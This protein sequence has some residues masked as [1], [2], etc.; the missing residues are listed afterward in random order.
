MMP[1]PCGFPRELSAEMAALSARVL[2]EDGAQPDATLMP[3]AE[4]RA[5]VE[6][7]NARWNRDLP[8]LALR[9]TVVVDADPVLGSARRKLELI[10]PENARPGALIFVHGGGFC[11][12]S[13]AT[14]ERCARLMAVESGLPV[15]VPDYRLA[16]EDSFPA[17]LHD[18]IAA[19]RNAFKATR[20][21]GVKAGPLLVAGDSAGANLA[22]AALLH[23]QAAG[24][25][26]IAGALLFYGTY[27]C[28]F[29]TP[30]Y[31]AFADGP[32]LTQAKMQRYWSAYAG[33]RHVERLAA[34]VLASPLKASD[35]AL[36]RLP[37]LYLM[38]AGIDPLL[39]DTLRLEA[40]LGALGR[41]ETT[42]IH[43]GVVHGFLQHSIDL[44]AAREALRLAGGQARRM[45][46]KA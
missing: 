14:H 42:T 9:E 8:P 40:R 7:A 5:L 31:A 32:G 10:V 12:C 37:P 43:P 41:S 25:P 34:D 18:V 23:E 17:G 26:H 2:A 3:W 28:D 33:G 30:S 39:S 20:H 36:S 19:L 1:E 16:P 22:L 13:P 38:A 35:E 21:L 27:G 29:A 44:E 11:F 45:A 6:R 15:L 4:G 24:Q 46:S